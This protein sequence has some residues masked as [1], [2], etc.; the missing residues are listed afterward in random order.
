MRLA[1]AVLGRSSRHS[2]SLVARRYAG[3]LKAFLEQVFR[4][5]FIHKSGFFGG[6]VLTRKSARVVVTMGM[7]ALIYRWYYRAH[8]LRSLEQNI[9]GFARARPV[10]DTIISG[11]ANLNQRGLR[12]LIRTFERLG[13]HG[14]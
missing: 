9:L 4:P 13:S 1:L 8:S 12:R 7:P 3:A 6:G 2:L 5:A 11:V 14:A 10:H